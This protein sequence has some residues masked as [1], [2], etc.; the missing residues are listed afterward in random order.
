MERKKII[1]DE[2]KSQMNTLIF[3]QTVFYLAAS[4][5]V[6]S[7]AILF[8]MLIYYLANI[9]KNLNDASKNIRDASRDAK[10]KIGDILEKLSDF[11][12]LS[13]LKK[14]KRGK[15]KGRDNL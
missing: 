3:A 12:F 6:V 15:T 5:A 2:E 8:A 14:H 7:V 1:Y 4:L 13:F 10:E 9:A 11:P